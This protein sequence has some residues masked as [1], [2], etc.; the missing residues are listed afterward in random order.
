MSHDFVIF[1]VFFLSIYKSL[2]YPHEDL[3]SVQEKLLKIEHHP[4]ILCS[5]DN[6]S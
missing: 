4:S 1:F 5:N 3:D 2:F 6:F